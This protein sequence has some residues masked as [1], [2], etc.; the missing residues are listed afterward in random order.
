MTEIQNSKQVLGILMSKPN[1]RT[2]PVG[3]KSVLVI[4][5]WDLFGI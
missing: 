1:E 3:T 5:Y 2:L 4:G